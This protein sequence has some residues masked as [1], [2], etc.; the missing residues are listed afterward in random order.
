METPHLLLSYRKYLQNLTNLGQILHVATV[1]KH[2]FSKLLV[3]QK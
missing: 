3:Q 2:I 1:S